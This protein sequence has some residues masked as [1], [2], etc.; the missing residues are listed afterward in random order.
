MSCDAGEATE[1]LENEA[2]QP[3]IGTSLTSPG[4]SSMLLVDIVTMTLIHAHLRY[5]AAIC[6][7]SIQQQ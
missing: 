6:R 5:Y 1:G 2:R 7:H 3:V 4:E